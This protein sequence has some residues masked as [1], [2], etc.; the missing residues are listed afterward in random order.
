MAALPEVAGV[1]SLV[2]SDDG[3]SA[4]LPV[5]LDVDGATGTAAEDVADERIDAVLGA[6]AAVA[7]GASRS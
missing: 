3:R 2:R 6:T 1:G 4:L 5:V 7:E